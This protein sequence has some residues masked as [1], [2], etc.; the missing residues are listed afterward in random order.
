MS[1]T[2]AVE[3]RVDYLAICKRAVGTLQRRGICEWIER[4]ELISEGCLALSAAKPDK[5]A[6]AVKIA[7]DAMIDTIRKHERRERGRVEV[8]S[9]YCSENPDAVSDGD[10]WDATVHG[11]QNLQPV[12]THMD[13]W[14]A[15]KALPYRQ[16]QAITLAFWGGM[17]ESSIGGELGITQQA[18]H[19]LLEKAKKNLREGVVIS[20]SHTVTNVRGERSSAGR[21]IGRNGGGVGQ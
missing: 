3:V 7:R 19:A 9:G 21:P 13:L 5:D 1:G 10:Q 8:R 4:E 6:L 11:K 16:Y 18:A 15:M 17:S 2:D 12:N 20:T 14:E